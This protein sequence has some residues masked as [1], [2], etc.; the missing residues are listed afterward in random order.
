MS[1]YR[2]I[3]YPGTDPSLNS[4]KAMIYSDWMKSLRFGN[5]W[6]KLIDSDRYYRGY[7]AIIRQLMAKPETMVR[8]AVLVD[9]PDTCLGWVIHEGGTL[10]YAF[11]KK[12]FRRQGI[13]KALLPK[14]I[15]RITHLTKI[16]QAI[17]RAKF[18]D[19]V[20]DPFN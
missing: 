8:L 13:A 17:R 19:T 7:G 5:D 14:S 2:V 15:A 10:H 4:Y 3:H 9:D 6:F 12:D 1:G 18:H 11:V 20:F 16:G